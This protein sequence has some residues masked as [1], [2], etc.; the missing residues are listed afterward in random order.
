M[1]EHYKRNPNAN[2]FVCKNPVYRRPVQLQVSKGRA[3]C[4]LLCYGISQR[5]E[6]PCLVCDL[7]ILA[8]KH[9]RTCSRA[10]ANKYR[11]GI[12][13]KIG[14]PLKDKVRGQRALKI[15]L[16]DQRGAKCER[17][18]YKKVEILHVHHR[19][20][21]RNNN[22]LENLELI[23]PNCHGEEHHLENSWLNGSVNSQM[24]GSDS[25]SFQR[26]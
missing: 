17:C 13:Y 12:K 11:A 2:C 4:S 7:P 8:S 10:C 21:N 1:G 24:E 25:G 23:C 15:R 9:A 26:T 5:K 22:S 16:I 3:F 20:R 18:G 6:T 19:D 14:R